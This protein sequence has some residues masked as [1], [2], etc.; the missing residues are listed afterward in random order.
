MSSPEIKKVAES[1]T[2]PTSQTTSS[3]LISERSNGSASFEAAEV[4]STRFDSL[5]LMSARW[6][7]DFYLAGDPSQGTENGQIAL[8]V[9][10]PNASGDLKRLELFLLEAFTAA[11]L[12]HRN[13][14]RSSQP[15]QINGIYY[16]RL[17][18]RPE[19]ETLEDRLDREG[20][21]DIR[22]AVGVIYQ[23]ADA[24]EYA[25][26]RGVL[27]LRIQP[28][29]ILI[30]SDGT[31]LLTDFGIEGKSDLAW[32]RMERASHC[33]IHYISPEQA[34]GGALD[35]RS[36]LYSLGVVLYQLLTDRLPVDSE[37]PESVRQKHL[38]QSPLSPH[39]YLSDIPVALSEVITCLL[40]KDPARRFQDVQ[41]FRAALEKSI[42]STAPPTLRKEAGQFEDLLAGSQPPDQPTNKV[43][44]IDATS[45]REDEQ[46]NDREEATTG[47]DTR[48]VSSRE[49]WET[50]SIG[51]IH[52]PPDSVHSFQSPPETE[53]Q[54]RPQPRV[55]L[56]Q[57]EHL[58]NAVSPT[59]LSPQ[60]ATNSQL[61]PVI[62][63]VVLAI[64]AVGGLLVLARFDRSKNT[65]PTPVQIPATNSVRDAA[66]VRSDPPSTT[67]EP[68]SSVINQPAAST[69]MPGNPDSQ[70]ESTATSAIANRGS[71]E[72]RAQPGTVRRSQQRSGQAKRKWRRPS[73]YRGNYYF[74]R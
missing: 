17:E 29:N 35:G 58:I 49:K 57:A 60:Q 18:H 2:S 6:D 34:R 8:K 3:T 25:H 70:A 14:L 1:A 52:P 33:P 15:E 10:P 11:K 12:T 53:P 63:V 39:L 16:C 28:E 51:M 13:I 74:N 65:S 46:G 71:S 31:A 55:E 9:F 62:L 48:V 19:A 30:D 66:S 26:E 5:Q 64:A 41:S 37:D 7:A 20:W 56:E 42:A 24:L 36:D 72:S 47:V 40:E 68:N 69:Q 43:V 59:L 23:I 61:S 67:G 32:A 27:H 54:T 38:T 45:F 4:L 21:L 50:P 44:E 73:R 22:T